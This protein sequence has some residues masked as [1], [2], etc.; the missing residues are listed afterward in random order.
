MLRL[1]YCMQEYYAD[2]S[3]YVT[4]LVSCPKGDIGRNCSVLTRKGLM[5]L[6]EA[7]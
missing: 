7:L 5:C 3:D 6:C 2:S 1:Q 4:C